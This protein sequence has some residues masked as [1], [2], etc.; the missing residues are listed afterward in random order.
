[1]PKSKQNMATISMKEWLGA[2]ERSHVLPTDK[3]YLDF[4]NK[5]HPIVKQSA[6]FKNDDARSLRDAATSLTYC[7]RTNG[8]STLPQASCPSSRPLPCSTRKTCVPKLTQP[9]PSA[10]TFKMPL[11]KAEA[12]KPSLIC[13][14]NY[15]EIICHF[16]P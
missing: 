16:T 11:P 4:A 12:G 2:N 9:S 8:T 5:L 15:T 10:C 7:Q 13:I 1:M 6:M 14:L 3:W